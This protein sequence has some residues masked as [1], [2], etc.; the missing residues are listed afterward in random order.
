MLASTLLMLA[1]ALL[2]QIVQL[3]LWGALAT[4][5]VVGIGALA[6]F[7]AFVERRP[8]PVGVV[9]AGAA[10]LAAALGVAL[11]LLGS[12]SLAVFWHTS[13]AARESLT[14]RSELLAPLLTAS[15]WLTV[16]VVALLPAVCE[17]LFYRGALRATLRSWDA[18]RRI[19][20]TATFFALAHFDPWSAP[21]LFCVGL[22]LGALAE[23]TDGWM[24]PAVAHFALN[25]FGI[26]VWARL[27][28]LEPPSAA[29]GATLVA[30]GLLVA[31]GIFV[32][33]KPSSS[34]PS[35]ASLHGS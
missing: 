12:G 23:R 8:L 13:A 4:Q 1:A 11:A 27:F 25:A 28:P 30:A 7:A 34:D 16:L 5:T 6:V 33:F 3:P 22:A 20:V 21:A 10:S 29:V 35:E 24:L 19:A 2:S 9:A 14:T 31:V 15:P 17:E 32:T 26:L 18:R